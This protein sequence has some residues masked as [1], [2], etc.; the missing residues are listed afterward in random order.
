MKLPEMKEQKSKEAID[1]IRSG[2]S[3][4]VTVLGQSKVKDEHMKKQRN[5]RVQ[6]VSRPL[7]SSKKI[8]F[9]G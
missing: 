3:V 4:Y 8:L 5:V 9:R 1:I 6:V 7:Y 2:L